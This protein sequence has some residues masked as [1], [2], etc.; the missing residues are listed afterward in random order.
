MVEAQ[1]VMKPKQIDLENDEQVNQALGTA[2]RNALREHKRLGQSVVVW[3]DGK[4]VTLAPDDIPVD[5]TNEVAP[6]PNQ[7]AKAGM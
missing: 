6:G 4:V 2:V 5:L 3:Q 7:A 1:T